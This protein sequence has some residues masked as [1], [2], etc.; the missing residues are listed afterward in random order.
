MAVTIYTVA[1]RAGVSISTVSLAIN[2][3]ERVNEATR[4][5]IVK[6]AGELGYRPSGGAADRARGSMGR[7]AVVAPFTSY[8]SYG[9]RLGGVL[10]AAAESGIDVIVHDLASAAAS[11]SPLL[12][13]LPVRGSLD[14]I[15]IMGLPLSRGGIELLQAWGPPIVLVDTQEHEF[16]S[17][18]LDDERGGYL[19]GRHLVDRGHTQIAFVHEAQRSFQYVSAGMLRL[20]GLK[21]ALDEAG[22]LDGL[23]VVESPD[24]SVEAGRLAGGQATGVSAVF[25]NHDQL[26]AG[27][28]TGLRDRGLDV[29]R[30]VALVGFDDGPLAQGLELTTVRQ[31]FNESGRVAAQLLISRIEKPGQS[32]QR[33]TLSPELVERRSTSPR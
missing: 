32:L 5:R 24:G 3:P 9:L 23:M 11:S 2:H 31:P 13:A 8:P 21:R 33:V 7:I 14:G 10:G 30:D 1:E 19:V 26:A 15:I 29:P 12:D 4:R 16:S 6:V 25:A 18:L 17:V 27:V 22:Q 20:S 28:L